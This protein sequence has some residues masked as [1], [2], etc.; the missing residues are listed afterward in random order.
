VKTLVFD[1]GNVVAWFSHEKAARQLA[2]FGPKPDCE[3][4]IKE[5][6]SHCF[7][8]P[9]DHAFE[10]G[11]LTRELFREKVKTPFDLTLS[12]AD[13]DNAFSDI[14]EPNSIIHMVLEQI[15]KKADRPRLWLLSNTTPLHIDHLQRQNPD[16]LRWF[17]RLALSYE[18]GCRK[19]EPSLYDQLCL[20]AGGDPS[21]LL[22]VDDLPANCEGARSRGWNAVCY[23]PDTDLLG[24]LTA[25]GW[26]N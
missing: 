18:L 19:P 24:A 1:L 11:Q 26:W 16:W 8:S 12:D 25:K 13:F 7:G 6:L 3:T 10:R 9:L 15:H 2:R 22:L 20:D 17:D 4:T 5:L 14:F 23:Q 21:D